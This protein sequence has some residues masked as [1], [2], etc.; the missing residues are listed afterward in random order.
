VDR[1]LRRT[2]LRDGTKD[3]IVEWQSLR[4]EA[5]TL[6]SVIRADS[7]L[8]MIAEMHGPSCRPCS[9]ATRSSLARRCAQWRPHRCSS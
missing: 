1:P 6:I 5:R 3:R 7:D 8:R 4:V 2:T 9:P